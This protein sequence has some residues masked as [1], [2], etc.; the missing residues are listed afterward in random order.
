VRVLSV[1]C[2]VEI[3]EQTHPSDTI[4]AGDFGVGRRV[5]FSDGVV[6][7]AIDV[8][9]EEKRKSFYQRRLKNKR[10]FSRNWRKVARKISKLDGRI[11]NIRKD[12]THKFTSGYIKNH[13]LIVLGNLHIKSMTTSAAGTLEQA[14]RK[15]KQK[16]GL[17]RAILRQGWGE[18]GRQLEYKQ[19]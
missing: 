19:S 1:E 4:A 3:A 18:L 17:N 6:V 11:A 9:W 10:K 16:S 7:P 12:E 5:T 15:V 13:A 8:S 14:G 2:K